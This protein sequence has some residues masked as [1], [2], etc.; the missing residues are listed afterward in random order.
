[1]KTLIKTRSKLV[2]SMVASSFFALGSVAIGGQAL[3]QQATAT[4]ASREHVKD[5][6]R[7]KSSVTYTVR[8][9]DLDI[10]KM[11]DAKTLYL[12]IRLAA[13]VVCTP[14]E[15]ASSWVA[16]QHR[17]CMDKA[18]ADAVAGVN[19][20]LLSQYHQLR[21]EHNKAGLVQLAKAN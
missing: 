11:K 18:I 8:F 9:S 3:A 2:N 19:R 5:L 16:E 7:T 14:L 20:P 21:L 12:R 4:E 6:S 1:M 17:A 13:E 15:S 10:S